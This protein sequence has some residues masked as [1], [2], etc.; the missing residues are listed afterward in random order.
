MFCGMTWCSITNF[1][2]QNVKLFINTCNLQCTGEDK[3]NDNLQEK[4]DQYPLGASSWI[5]Q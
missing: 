5:L 3:F 4:T 1:N 2:E